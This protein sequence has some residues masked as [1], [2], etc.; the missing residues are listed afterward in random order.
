MD[1]GRPRL[2]CYIA[3]IAAQMGRLQLIAAAV[4]VLQS[5]GHIRKDLQL[6]RVRKRL[7]AALQRILQAAEGHDLGDHAML[8]RMALICS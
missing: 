2:D 3:I 5:S 7:R 4:H 1:D 6:C 8:R